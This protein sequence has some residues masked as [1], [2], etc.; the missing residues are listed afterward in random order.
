MWPPQT[1]FY[2]NRSPTSGKKL[3]WPSKKAESNPMKEKINPKFVRLNSLESTSSTSSRSP[4]KEDMERL[5]ANVPPSAKESKW[6]GHYQNDYQYQPQSWN[7]HQLNDYCG[8]FQQNHTQNQTQYWPQYQYQVAEQ[9]Q[10]N[11]PHHHP[12][13]QYW[14][15]HYQ[16]QV[17][18]NLT[19][20]QFEVWEMEAMA[21]GIDQMS[22]SSQHIVYQG[23][24]QGQNQIYYP[25]AES[26]FSKCV[27][28]IF[29]WGSALV[30]TA[31]TAVSSTL[32][33]T[34]TSLI[35]SS[36]NPN[37]QV[38]TPAKSAMEA[39][40]IMSPGVNTKEIHSVEKSKIVPDELQNHE[41]T[42]ISSTNCNNNTSIE[43][44]NMVNDSEPV[45]P[46]NEP[47]ILLKTVNQRKCTPWLQKK[48]I[49]V[50]S[51]IDS[52]DII[53]DLDGNGSCSDAESEFEP[54]S[55]NSGNSHRLRLLSVC[56]SEDGIHFEDS[57]PVQFSASPKYKIDT[58]KCSPF[59]KSFLA[60]QDDLSEEESDED[61][62][63]DEDWDK[64]SDENQTGFDIDLEQFGLPSIPTIPMRTTGSSTDKLDNSTTLADEV[65]HNQL[66]STSKKQ[67]NIHKISKICCP[68][69]DRFPTAADLDY[70][71]ILKRVE[72]ANKKWD[73]LES[74]NP[75]KKTK[76][77][78]FT[79]PLVSKIQFEDPEMADQL[80][81]ARVGEYNCLQRRA[82]QDRY[83]R[84]LGPIFK[85]EHRDK[86]RSYIAKQQSYLN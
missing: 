24:H 64:V 1:A 33:E 25:E 61:D 21:T 38:F 62:D 69:G 57:S 40:E 84:L 71:Q 72:E 5:D 70:E 54:D 31:A 22:Y 52:E 35:T 8:Q 13:S 55:A 17:P 42:E 67:N 29:Q 6:F 66:I 56:S 51:D 16:Y 80:R 65:D 19:K 86:I 39:P 77:V 36:L 9:Q 28:S 74:K 68:E 73:T 34:T 85:P 58:N 48:S 12:N 81:E 4:S 3:Q 11:Y 18:Y 2:H 27:N 26:G 50:N 78:A 23:S 47:E 44:Q 75:E 41:N 46:P 76:N 79:E 37:A 7:Q 32:K 45:T 30:A 14:P 10:Q 43:K 20:G 53:E 63:D 82:D 49:K 59:L 60:G 15:Q 83:N